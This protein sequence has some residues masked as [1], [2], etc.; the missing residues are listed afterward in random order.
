M[1]FS[2]LVVEGARRLGL[3]VLTASYFGKEARGHHRKA[4]FTCAPD[5]RTPSAHSGRRRFRLDALSARSSR[6]ARIARRDE[7]RARERDGLLADAERVDQLAVTI[8]VLRL[9]VVEQA[10]ALAD[11]LEETTARVVILRVG[12]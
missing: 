7:T 11:Q 5:A 1:N 2:P 9:E 8:D 10:A 6:G 3:P 12:L 4:K